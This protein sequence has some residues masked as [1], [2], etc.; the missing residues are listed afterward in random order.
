MKSNIIDL[1]IEKKVDLNVTNE[2]T[3]LCIPKDKEIE[4]YSNFK[5]KIT[6]EKIV[7]N[8]QF[9]SV[10]EVKE[11]DDNLVKCFSKIIN[12]NTKQSI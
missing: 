5:F 2:I 6:N 4:K 3:K 7:K 9:N 10:Q 12:K 8:N 11:N 1:K